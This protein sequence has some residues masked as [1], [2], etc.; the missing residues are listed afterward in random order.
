MLPQPGDHTT[1]DLL[2][3]VL[4][5]AGYATDRLEEVLGG[6]GRI[7]FTP[8]DLVVHE[9][10][11]PSGDPFSTLV[12]LFLLGLPV[13]LGQATQA[14]RPLN[15]EILA[16]AG[17]LTRD[18]QEV[19]S[20]VKLVPHGDLLITS[21]RDAPGDAPADWVAG[22]HPPSVTL[23][24]LTVRRPVTRALDVATGNGIQAMLASRH[25]GTVVATDVNRRALAFA[26]LNA[27]LNGSSNVEVR[28]GSYFEPVEGELFHLITCNPPYVIS[29][30]SRY[31]YRDSGL[32]G[33][34][35]SRQVVEA[36]AEHLS[37]GGFAH[38]L[39]SWS[40]EPDDWWT[41]LEQW[42]EGRGC[43]A[44][45]LYF[46]SDDPVTHAAQWLRPVA[47]EDPGRFRESFTAWLDYL[48]RLGIT[49]IAHGA[50][51][52]RRRA[53]GQ[54]WTRRE[55]VLLDRVEQA[56]G[57]LLR[58]FDARDVL[59]APDGDR[60]LV[61]CRYALVDEHE[62]E[63]RLGFRDGRAEVRG[64][65]L[66]LDG[67]LGFRIGLDAHTA[68]LLPL[69]DGRRTLH[70]ALAARAAA[71][72]LDRAESAEFEAAALPVVRRLMELGFLVPAR[73]P[74]RREDG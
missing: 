30:E 12:R 73:P 48:E 4:V 44:L 67:G 65:V 43:D 28:D 22:M 25:A 14:L 41:P 60:D 5:E 2:R 68:Q 74:K 3:A 40:H 15:P 8:G 51:I 13:S 38:I 62:L 55:H 69:L 21:D 6:S 54:N 39:V 24:K 10:R 64:S 37:E 7:S 11:L 46:G 23:A 71:M 49:A 9:R 27:Q 29:P 33:D 52:L 47:A 16:E 20:T 31:V 26:Q 61:D 19:R 53:G 59:A 17:W 63:Q 35:V 50:V 42:V 66:A 57:H 45:L 18:G 56:S 34:T 32:R 70:E 1:L 36:A 58:L 72:R